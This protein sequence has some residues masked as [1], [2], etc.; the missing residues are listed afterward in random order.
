MNVSLSLSLSLSLSRCVCVCVCVCLSLS[1]SLSLSL[2]LSV[3]ERHE[4][5]GRFSTG[6]QLNIGELLCLV[7][8]CL[9]KKKNTH[10]KKRTHS[11]LLFLS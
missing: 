9:L 6:E 11:K 4:D 5:L 7:L 10:F 2:C 3:C 8:L 1:L